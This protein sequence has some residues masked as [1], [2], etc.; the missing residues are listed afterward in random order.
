METIL[1]HATTEGRVVIQADAQGV[2]LSFQ[3]DDPARNVG[4]IKVDGMRI[5]LAF[6]EAAKFSIRAFRDES[7]VNS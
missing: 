3:S 4:P 6:T 5:A 7:A 2:Y 1:I